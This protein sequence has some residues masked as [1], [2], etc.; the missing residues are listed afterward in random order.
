VSEQQSDEP[1]RIPVRRAPR[2]S[3]FLLTGAALGVLVA[4]VAA[5]SGPAGQDVSRGALLGYLVV[6]LGLLGG[7][8]GG[9]VA[10]VVDRRRH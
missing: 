4:L 2:Y 7:L 3:A 10:L 1:P 6:L 9:V 8:A 5:M